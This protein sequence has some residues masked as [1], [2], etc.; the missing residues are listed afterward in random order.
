VTPAVS[1]TT[2]HR[3]FRF[4]VFGAAAASGSEWKQIARRAEALG[5]S[6][7]HVADHYVDTASNGGQMLAPV[8]AIATAAAVTE[9]L[10]VGARVFCIDYHHPVVLAKTAATLDLL[11]DGRLE[12]GL[13]AGWVTSEYTSMGIEMDDAPTRIARLA[14]SVEFMKAFFSGEPIDI[15]ST[16]ASAHG[17]R[18][19]PL[20][21]QQPHPPIMIGGGGR[22]V[23]TLAGRCADIVSFNFNNA[24]GRV[25]ARGVQASSG[26]RMAERLSWVREGA[27]DRFPRLEL[28]VGGYFL[29]VTD[30][31]RS[32]AEAF[33][34]PFDLTADEMLEHPNALI[35]SIDAI[36]DRLVERRERFGISYVSVS[37]RSM[38]AFAPVVE[39]LAG[40]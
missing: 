24:E 32:T 6:A 39:R 3:P 20:P 4:A 22:R 1:T 38:D 9:R 33:G 25:A 5:Y 14:D 8:P 27:G 11:S 26:A 2:R 17:F 10:R 15:D 19:Q 23:L 7:L 34:K 13:G 40:T 12:F 36:C 18:G 30:D 16:A 29:A 37:T 28:E 31:A 21:V 35:G